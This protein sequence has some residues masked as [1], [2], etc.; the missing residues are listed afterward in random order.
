MAGR[1]LMM[2]PCRSR[3]SGG[4]VY[5]AALVDGGERAQS[6]VN[7]VCRAGVY[8]AVICSPAI[9][10]P[11]KGGQGGGYRGGPVRGGDGGGAD[12]FSRCGGAP[13]RG[14]AAGRAGFR[15]GPVVAILA[16]GAPH[17]KSQFLISTISVYNNGSTVTHVPTEARA[18]P[19]W[20]TTAAGATGAG[21]GV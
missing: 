20:T 6:P 9:P 1:A 7:G 11:V 18:G 15:R 12:M 8:P 17:V 21:Q 13:R 10:C 4:A 5:P 14:A 3:A 16:W 2:G 19:P